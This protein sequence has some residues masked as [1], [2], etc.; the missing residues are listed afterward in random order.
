MLKRERGRENK[1]REKKEGSRK[2]D[3]RVTIED[4]ALNSKLREKSIYESNRKAYMLFFFFF[5]VFCLRDY[6]RSN[7]TLNVFVSYR[8]YIK[9]DM[10]KRGIGVDIQGFEISSSKHYG[11]VNA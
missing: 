7:Y 4:F 6:S 2:A 1:K 8:T 3:E 9:H 11:W 5:F 10:R